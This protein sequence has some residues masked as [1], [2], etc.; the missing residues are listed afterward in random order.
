VTENKGPQIKRPIVMLH[1]PF[2]GAPVTGK[3]LKGATTTPEW[4]NDEIPV[5]E[6]VNHMPEYLETG[7]IVVIIRDASEKRDD[8]ALRG[9][10]V[11]TMGERVTGQ[12]NVSQAF[13][14]DMLCHG[15]LMGK[16]TGSFKWEKLQNE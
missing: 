4:N 1:S 6:A 9:S 3:E 15:R 13:E 11:L 7:H 8:K 2:F 5:V 14:L 10:G 16:I 12:F